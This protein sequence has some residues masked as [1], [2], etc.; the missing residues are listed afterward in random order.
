MK[1]PAPVTQTV[2]PDLEGEEEASMGMINWLEEER[3]VEDLFLSFFP[4][5][6]NCKVGAERRN[7]GN[8][9]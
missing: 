1:P 2:W 9:L 5:F 7:V 6:K 4:S 3:L 8:N